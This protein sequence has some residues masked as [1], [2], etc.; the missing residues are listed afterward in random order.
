MI[1]NI[2]NNQLDVIT[3]LRITTIIRPTNNFTTVA[4]RVNASSLIHI[5]Y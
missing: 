2:V 1:F 3:Y 4:Q 5:I